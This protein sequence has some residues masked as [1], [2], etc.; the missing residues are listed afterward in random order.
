MINLPFRQ[1]ID[2]KIIN[3]WE[4]FTFARGGLTAEAPKEKSEK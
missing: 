3:S 4:F 2:A 1:F